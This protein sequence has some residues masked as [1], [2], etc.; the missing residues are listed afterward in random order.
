MNRTTHLIYS[1]KSNILATKLFP[2]RPLGPTFW[3]SVSPGEK[4]ARIQPRGLRPHHRPLHGLPSFFSYLCLKEL[5]REHFRSRFLHTCLC[6][7]DMSQNGWPWRSLCRLH[8]GR[9]ET[10]YQQGCPS[11]SR[12]HF[13]VSV[14]CLCFAGYWA[15]SSILTCVYA[16]KNVT[17]C[18][19]T[20]NM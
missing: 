18:C 7:T 15:E 1:L 20:Q 19:C 17:L 11:C 9:A 4:G 13:Q 3:G 6:R 8:R 14:F 10:V 5:G 16:M 12:Q 2:R